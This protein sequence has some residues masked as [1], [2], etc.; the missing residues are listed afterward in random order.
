ME[1]GRRGEGRSL[2]HS[3]V[4]RGDSRYILVGKRSSIAFIEVIIGDR[5]SAYPMKRAAFYC[6]R[7][8]EVFHAC[9][10]EISTNHLLRNILRFPNYAL[11][12][13]E[14]C[15]DTNLLRVSK[16]VGSLYEE[17]RSSHTALFTS[18]PSYAYLMV[19]DLLAYTNIAPSKPFRLTFVPL[20]IHLVL[21]GFLT[22]LI[23]VCSLNIENAIYC[24]RTH[25]KM[26]I[27]T[28]IKS[29]MF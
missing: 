27:M 28:M 2:R 7:F 18:I 23:D 14:R 29:L 20:I 9:H 26:N 15:D 5:A 6:R 8:S 1:G 10:A 4:L 24:T 12:L 25:G 19:R 13:H 16:Y 3:D 17:A 22:T 11:S 21:L